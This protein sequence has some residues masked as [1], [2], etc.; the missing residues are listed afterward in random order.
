M[1]G[2][3]WIEVF[4]N[5]TCKECIDYIH[6]HKL[7]TLGKNSMS[8][9]AYVIFLNDH[10][11]HWKSFKQ[12]TVAKSSTDSELVALCEGI[13]DMIWFI[14]LFKELCGKDLENKI[15]F[16]D[17]T[18][19]VALINCGAPTTRSRYIDKDIAFV[20]RT[21]ENLKIKILKLDTKENI[22]DVLTK[23]LLFPEFKKTHFKI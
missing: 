19:A 20:A 6:R 23:P 21:T 16:C 5:K 2:R 15:L 10:L 18:P 12:K 9:C 7:G 22:A 13:T 8:K 11:I 17:S 4:K 3:I 1:N 14:S